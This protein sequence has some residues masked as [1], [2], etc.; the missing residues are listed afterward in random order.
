MNQ[1]IKQLFQISLFF[2]SL[3]QGTLS[4]QCCAGGSGCTI[5]G[6]APTG[7]LQKHQLMLGTSFQYINSSK[8]YKGSDPASSSIRTFDSFRSSYEYFTLGYG[9]TRNLTFSVE[10]G[11][12]FQ[13]KETGLE[14]NPATTYEASGIGD[15][16]LFPRY[17]ILNRLDEKHHDEITLGLGYK[18][19]LGSYNDST[20]TIEP[21]SGDVFYVTKPTAVQLSSGAQDLIFYTFIYRGYTKKNFAIFGNAY[22][23]MKGYN[24]NGE[25]LGDYLSLGVFASKN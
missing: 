1:S 24:P 5:A 3:C 2:F 8:F 22:Y 15:L 20:G 23:I 18:I 17:D 12:Y 9:L 19:P 13:K 10:A 7:V 14:G 25:K 6:G 11:Y 16:I 4:S 21:F